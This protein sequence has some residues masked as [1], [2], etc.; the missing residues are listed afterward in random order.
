MELRRL[1]SEDVIC[2]SVQA[3]KRDDALRELLS[4][5][6]KSGSVSEEQL[7]PILKALLRREKLGST[8]V[9]KGM[10]VPHA[11]VDD[12]PSTLM[13]LGVSKQGVEFRA[14]DREPVH[15]IFLVIGPEKDADEYIDVLRR[16]SS[17]IQNPDFRRFLFRSQT[18]AEVLELVAEMDV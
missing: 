3:D 4:L 13:A 1:L 6:V 17:L 5:F 9:G 12:I 8:A 11:R 2:A 10:A 15:G 18:G 16:I 7:A 14:L